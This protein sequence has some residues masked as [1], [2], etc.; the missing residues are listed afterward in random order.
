MTQSRRL[1]CLLLGLWMGAG[2]WIAWTTVESLHSVDRL[3]ARPDAVARIEVKEL[4]PAHARLLLDYEAA[5]MTRSQLETW[6]IAQILLGGFFF[7]FLLF[8]T[9]ERKLSLLLAL[10]MILAVMIERFL[11]TP[12]L[13]SLGRANDFVAAI[14]AADRTRIVMLRSVY[15][16]VE[17]FKWGCGAVLAAKLVLHRRTRSGDIR[18]KVYGVDKSDHGHVNG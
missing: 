11:I 8:G 3:L 5:E 16:M 9:S 10:L 17:V 7:L 1:A 14:G 12:E 15:L 13:V 18:E 4:G 6:E 2:L